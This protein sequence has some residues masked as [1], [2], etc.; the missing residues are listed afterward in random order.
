M[1]A[2]IQNH[3][4]TVRFLFDLSESALEHAVPVK[5][6]MD[7]SWPFMCVAVLFTKESIQALRSGVL[8]SYCN[9][10][11]DVLKS[12]NEFHHACFSEFGR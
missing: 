3:P 10:Y 5:G 9:K 1:L 12:L 6:K 2:F 4:T 7:T 11:Q 8:H